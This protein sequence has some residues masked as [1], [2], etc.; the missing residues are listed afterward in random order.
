MNSSQVNWD[1][2]SY[3]D[4]G[5]NYFEEEEEEKIKEEE[6]IEEKEKIEEVESS[7]N[8]NDFSEFKKGDVITI[9]KGTYQGHSGIVAGTTPKMV[10][11]TILSDELSVDNVRVLKTSIRHKN[12]DFTEFKTGNVI[13]IVKGT[14]QGHSGI[15]AGTTP[16]MVYI[17]FLSDELSVGKVRILNSSVRHS[18]GSNLSA[19]L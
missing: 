19:F 3:D 17:T 6:M 9:D 15:V 2:D 8:I 10:Y 5:D 7:L 16:K 11:I 14:Y 18:M 13:T 1:E 12:N 4:V